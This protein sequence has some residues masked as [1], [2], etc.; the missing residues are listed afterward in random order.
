MDRQAVILAPIGEVFRAMLPPVA[1]TDLR[2]EIVLTAAGRGAA[3]SLGGGEIF[4][5]LSA[6]E[7]AFLEKA[8]AQKGPVLFSS[9]VKMGMS[10]AALQRLQRLGLI[11]IRETLLTQKKIAND[12]RVERICGQS[13]KNTEEKK[14]R[15]GHCSKPNA[16]R[17]RFH[18]CSSSPRYRG[19]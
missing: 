4:H 7:A 10:S 16:V 14:K 19:V 8:D 15:S 17:C 1:S 6:A 3:E 11:E 2:R 9:T 18:D 5:G 12:C 13:R